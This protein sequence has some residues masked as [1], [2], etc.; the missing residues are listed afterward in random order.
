MII[1][2]C[3]QGEE[4]WFKEKLGKPS[5]S[6]ASKLITNSG[7]P[8]KQRTAYIYELVAE[9]LTN[10]REEGFKNENILM[11]QER[12]AESRQ[13]Y[14]LINNVEVTQ[15]GVV[16]KDNKKQFLCSPDG[17]INNEYGLELKNVLPKTQVKNLLDGGVP[18]EYF[19]Q[20]QFSLYVTGFK[21]W[22]FMTYSP[23]LPVHI[24]KV[25]RNEVFIKALKVELELFCR[26]L[27]IVEEKL[28][29]V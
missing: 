19:S 28:R 23:A 29:G 13:L 4:V 24:I 7:E 11:G 26:E 5:A 10:K 22:D 2:D 16:Y 12:E 25:E 14:E 1:V 18:S 3:K 20:I 6:N 17:I 21:R 15:V 9:I 8:S 27:A